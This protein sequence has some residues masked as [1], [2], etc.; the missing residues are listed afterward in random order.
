MTDAKSQHRSI[1]LSDYMSR[2]VPTD[3]FPPGD[4]QPILLGIFGEVGSIMATA[5]K[6]HREKEAYAGYR[7]AVEEEFGDALWYFTAL[8]PKA[9]R[10]RADEIFASVASGTGYGSSIAANDLVE[11]PVSHVATPAGG[12]GTRS[13]ALRTRRGRGSPSCASGR[14][15][16]RG[17]SLSYFCELLS[18]RP[19]GGA[20]HVLR[21][22]STKNLIKT[23]GRFLPPDYG[24]LA[25]FLTG[26]LVPEEQ[27]P[28][29]FRDYYRSARQWPQ[30]LTDEWCFHR[31]SA[32]R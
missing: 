13:R 32:D 7:H 25:R 19:Q 5:K 30:L 18:A 3:E 24:S 22:S 9:R 12:A 1:L 28:R 16:R 4:L 23:M 26:T 31:R 8:L 10:A 11:S 21:K 2:V 15:H 27:L 20:R 17:G 6:F 29:R 14:N